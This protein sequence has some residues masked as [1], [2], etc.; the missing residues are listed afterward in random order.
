MP[1]NSLN[2]MLNETRPHNVGQ[3]LLT[4]T[5]G[6]EQTL[7]N[8]SGKPC[9]NIAFLCEKKNDFTLQFLPKP[10][11]RKNLSR[12]IWDCLTVFYPKLWSRRK[13]E[14]AFRAENPF[15]DVDILDYSSDL[16][17]LSKYQYLILVGDMITD[18]EF[19]HRL[20]EYVVGGGTLLMTLA[21]LH[22]GMPDHRTE[23]LFNE[24]ICKLTG[25]LSADY[26]QEPPLLNPS[27]SSSCILERRVGEGRVL[28]VH[29]KCYLWE[30]SIW[31]I[32]KK[33]IRRIAQENFDAQR[34]RGWVSAEKGIY[35]AAY[36]AWDRRIF[37]LRDVR[38]RMRF[39]SARAALHMGNA[40][41]GFPVER[42]KINMVTLFPGLGVLPVEGN[43][44]LLSFYG[45]SLLVE[46]QGCVRIIL[47]R[48]VDGEIEISERRLI[49]NGKETE[50]I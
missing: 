26:S 9:V 37:Y 18:N 31:P 32:C 19:V 15:G 23:V 42:G 20:L 24:N 38:S 41:C 28:I 27:M 2:Q 13:K 17:I 39:G 12:N 40:V 49:L 29:S 34:M 7:K 6:I 8:F 48:W 36:E 46:G 11:L 22:T 1:Q 10:W 43:V 25:L 30:K 21:H 16:A 45:D 14:S 47:F 44:K 50:K 33:Q 3:A 35:T 5:D 4:G